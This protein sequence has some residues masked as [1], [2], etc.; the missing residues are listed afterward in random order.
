M[1]AHLGSRSGLYAGGAQ[2]ARTSIPPTPA[3][4]TFTVHAS[5]RPAEVSGAETATYATSNS[6]AVG[7]GDT[8]GCIAKGCSRCDNT[9]TEQGQAGSPAPN[10]E[11]KCKP[12]KSK[13]RERHAQTQSEQR[14]AQPTRNPAHLTHHAHAR[15]LAHTHERTSTC[16][17]K[18]LPLPPR[19]VSL[20]TYP[21]R[22]RHARRDKCIGQ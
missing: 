18:T 11:S 4:H 9:R 3:G 14:I 2:A 21:H 22:R 20:L 13:H 8:S 15:T 1:C 12:H 17:G 6:N 19:A 5:I 10:H 16:A 7:V